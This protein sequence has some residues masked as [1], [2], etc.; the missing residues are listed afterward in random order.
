MSTL[1]AEVLANRT[2]PYSIDG[3]VYQALSATN[4]EMY[5]ITEKEAQD[6]MKFILETEGIDI[7]PPAAVAVASLIKAIAQKKIDSSELILLNITGGGI[8]RLKEDNEL[9]PIKPLLEVKSPQ[10]DLSEIAEICG[11]NNNLGF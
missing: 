9:I 2:P 8:N 1:F 7:V 5:A 10:A 4:G 3:G 11:L 6:A